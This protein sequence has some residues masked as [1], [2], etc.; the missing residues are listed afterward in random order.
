MARGKQAYPVAVSIDSSMGVSLED[1]SRARNASSL[2]S[3]LMYW[4][5]GGCETKWSILWCQ[6][7]HS[8]RSLSNPTFHILH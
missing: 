5:Q 7:R 2:P 4:Q 1:W 6:H 3:P 8:D